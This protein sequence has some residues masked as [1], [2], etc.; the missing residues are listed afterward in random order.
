MSISY[1]EERLTAD[2]YIDFLKRTDLELQYLR[3]KFYERISKLVI[4]FQ[5]VLLLVLQKTEL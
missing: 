1:K 4:M 2:E 3:E 5:L